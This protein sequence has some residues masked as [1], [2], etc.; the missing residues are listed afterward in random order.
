MHDLEAAIS[1]AE[2]AVSATPENHPDQATLLNNL[3]LM[4]LDLHRRTGNMH[5]LEAAISKAEVAVA[6]TPENHSGRARLLNSLGLLLSD[7]YNR[8]EI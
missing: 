4:L 8:Q 6:A 5:G 3:G 1:K 2:L 7:R